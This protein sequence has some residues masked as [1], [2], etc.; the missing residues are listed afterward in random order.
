MLLSF[1]V[2]GLILQ[3]LSATTRHQPTDEVVSTSAQLHHA[4]QVVV[5]EDLP[6]ARVQAAV[7]HFGHFLS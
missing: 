2:T 5:S 7:R 6:A 3:K 4:L 1:I